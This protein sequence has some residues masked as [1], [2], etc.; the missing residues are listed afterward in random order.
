M[1]CDTVRRHQWVCKMAIIG[2]SVLMD[3]LVYRFDIVLGGAAII[4]GQRDCNTDQVFIRLQGEGEAMLM[5][6]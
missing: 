6:A 2:K 4:T 3:G 5:D 1:A